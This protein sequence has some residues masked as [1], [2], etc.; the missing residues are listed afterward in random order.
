MLFRMRHQRQPDF[1]SGTFIDTEGTVYPIGEDAINAKI[2]K[3]STVVGREMPLNWQI[4]IP[5]QD[6]N[7]VISPVRD[8][9]WNKGMFSY[10]EGAITVDGSHNGVGFMEL[11]GY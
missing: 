1:W 9:Q 3:L 7:I 10:Y 6:L 8:N 11:T 5:S 2:Q 4:T